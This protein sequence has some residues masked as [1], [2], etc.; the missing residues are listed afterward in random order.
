VLRAVIDLLIEIKALSEADYEIR[1]PPI[2]VMTDQEKADVAGKVAS[3]A[4]LISDAGAV[5]GRVVISV[6]EFREKYLNLPADLPP[7]AAKELDN[8]VAP[9]APFGAKPGAPGQSPPG[10]KPGEKP[11]P[12]K[13]PPPGQQPPPGAKPNGAGAANE[14]V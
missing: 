9:P 3:A 4:R 7:E 14:N 11:P 2:L 8:R 13:Q 10:A 12:G 1:W 6:S 5:T